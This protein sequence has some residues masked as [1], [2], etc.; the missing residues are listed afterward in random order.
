MGHSDST[1][2]AGH[3]RPP[4]HEAVILRLMEDFVTRKSFN[5]HGFLVAI[6]SLNKIGE[7]RIWDLTGD[8]PFSMTFNVL[9]R[10]LTMARYW[11][12][13]WCSFP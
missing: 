11:W 5:E 3:K 7:E 8:I 4:P 1:R 12:K 10:D 2:P 13:Q 9:C 6:T